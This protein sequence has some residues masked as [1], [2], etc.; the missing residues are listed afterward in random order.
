MP[1]VASRFRPAWWLRNAHLQTLWPFLFRPPALPTPQRQR[2]ETPDGDFIDLAWFGSQDGPRVLL[3]HGL[4]G[5]IDSHY[6]RRTVHTLNSAGYRSCVLQFRGCSG[7][8]NRLARSYHSGDSADLDFVLAQLAQADLSPFALVG[9]SLGG[10]VLL[11]WLGESTGTHTSRRSIRCAMA[12]SVP[13][14]LNDAANR[15]S[16]GPSRLYQN[17]LL[18]SLRAKCREKFRHHPSPTRVPLKQL[19]SFRLFDDQITAPLHGFADVEDY[20]ERASCGQYLPRID[21]PTLILHALDDPFMFAHTPPDAHS[22]PACVQLELTRR[23][24]HV[25][26]VSGAVP[27]RTRNWFVE[28]LLDWLD[29]HRDGA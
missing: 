29:E 8:P 28:R 9:F 26:F 19:N 2:L 20:Y 16:R 10:N 15:M 23:G 6:I 17:H 25:G 27:W 24:G 12:V 21:T 5:G 14:Q 18:G 13:F 3:L 4:E 11:K 22:L 7:E 1:R